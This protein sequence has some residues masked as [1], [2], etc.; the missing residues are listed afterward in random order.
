MVVTEG[1]RKE[2]RKERANRTRATGHGV[3]NY[4]L[5]SS[6]IDSSSPSRIVSVC[7]SRQFMQP[8]FT[9]SRQIKGAVRKVASSPIES[10]LDEKPNDSNV[11]RGL[12]GAGG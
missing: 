2:G 9:S 6:F 7:T 3:R 1:G 4:D 10:H 8:H 12:P 5:Y 11:T